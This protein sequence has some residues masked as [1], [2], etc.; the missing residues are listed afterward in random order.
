MHT[1]PRVLR[2][3]VSRLGRA[4]LLTV[5]LLVLVAIALADLP[6]AGVLGSFGLTLALALQAWRTHQPLELR[7]LDDGTLELRDAAQAWQ[8]A[9]VLPRT[10]V[11]P[12][13]CVLAYRRAGERSGR[14]IALLPDHLEA[15]DYRRLRVWLRWRA[16]VRDASETAS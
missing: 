3:R 1:A 8:P 13:L 16:R 11:T 5:A 2:L 14:S 12:W 7:L 15:E 9:V 10:T 6:P 4:A